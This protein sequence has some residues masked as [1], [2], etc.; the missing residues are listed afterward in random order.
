M[1][2]RELCTV[3]SFASLIGGAAGCLISK[4][5]LEKS[6][7]QEFEQV[8]KEVSETIDKAKKEIE[9]INEQ[10]DKAVR[11]VYDNEAKNAFEKRKN[12]YY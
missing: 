4:A 10:V 1:K 11:F 12:L 3:I 7:K 6:H 2:N 9:N 5:I 8:N